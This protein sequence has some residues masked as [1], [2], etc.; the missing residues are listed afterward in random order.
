MP[1]FQYDDEDD[2]NVVDLG[3]F[4]PGYTVNAGGVS[5]SAGT[6]AG[7]YK[8][9]ARATASSRVYGLGVRV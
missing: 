3:T 6:S 2:E 8:V 1:I 9:C 4:A 7:V 5:G